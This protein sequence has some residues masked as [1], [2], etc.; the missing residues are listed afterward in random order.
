MLIVLTGVQSYTLHYDVFA[1][2]EVI[3]QGMLGISNGNPSGTFSLNQYVASDLYRGTGRIDLMSYELTNQMLSTIE[4]LFT[5]SITFDFN[6]I[7]KELVLFETPQ[8]DQQVMV[9]CYRKLTPQQVANPLAFVAGQPAMLEHTNIYN[10]L[11]I[12]SM[13]TEKARWQW[14]WNLSKYAGSQ[15]P[16]GLNIDV[17]AMISAATENIAKWEEKLEEYELPIDMM[18]GVFLLF[19]MVCGIWESMWTAGSTLLI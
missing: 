16:N 19:I 7:S 13:A 14:A 9:H 12:R 5:N 10:E 4:L 3:G 6:C 11:W 17:P 15:L 2:L 18:I 1:I 8:F